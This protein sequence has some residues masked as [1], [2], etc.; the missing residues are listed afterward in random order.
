MSA[1]ERT[2]THGHVGFLA[3]LARRELPAATK[4]CVTRVALT[5]QQARR[6]A[7]HTIALTRIRSCLQTLVYIDRRT[8]EGKTLARV[9]RTDSTPILLIRSSQQAGCLACAVRSPEAWLARLCPS[10]RCWLRQQRTSA[11]RLVR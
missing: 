9:P 5:L 7:I 4:P 2:S 1:A 11:P 8:A 3:Y 10:L 6:R